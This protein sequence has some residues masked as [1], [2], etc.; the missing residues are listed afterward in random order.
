L[1]GRY[2]GVDPGVMADRELDW[3][4]SVKGEAQVSHRDGPGDGLKSDGP[5]DK[6]WPLP[7]V[8]VPTRRQRT[9]IDYGPW[10]ELYGPWKELAL[11]VFSGR[12]P[13]GLEVAQT[14]S[15]AGLRLRSLPAG[16]T[17]RGSLDLR[18]CQRLK[19]IG[20]RLD[21]RDDLMIGGRCPEAPWWEASSAADAP[22]EGGPATVLRVLSRDHQCPLAGLPSGL[23]VGR[24]LRLRHCRRLERLPDDIR[25][26]RSVYLEGCTSLAWLPSQFAVHGDLTVSAAPSLTSLPPGLRVGGSLRLVGVRVERLPEGLRVGGDLILECCPR[27]ATLPDR[28]DVGGSL[29]VRRCPIDRLPSCLRVGRDVRLHRLP[30]LTSLPESLSVPGRL[31][32]NRC[33][34]LRGIAHGIR[35]GSD[36]IIRRCEGVRDL[37]E[38]L[39][40]PGTLDLRGCTNLEALPKGLDVGSDL[41][42]RFVPALRLADC[43]ALTSLP[44]DLTVGGPIDVAGSGLRGLPERLSRSARILWRGVVVPPEVIFRPETLTPEQ[45][46]GQRNAELRRVMLERVGLDRVLQKAKAEVVDS[47]QDP[48][49]ARRLVRMA[50]AGGFGRDR[51]RCY[52]HC[53]CPSTGREYLLRV[54]PETRTCRQAAAWLAGFEDPEAYRP[55]LET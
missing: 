50:L 6:G 7:S 30:D 2:E 44:E 45:I 17:V 12:A 34:S 10:K 4:G 49:G 25:I 52:L 28:L 37:P 33:P 53:R 47:D 18:Q 16:M 54:P 24:D 14:L 39:H 19:R 3:L 38:G 1:P 40:I 31:E 41:G 22:V 5:E 32:L 43:P 46:L 26:G 51:D 35:V 48:G 11:L 13:E 36:L 27:L 23:R 9:P 21:V 15:L 29:V 42:T 8:K 20:D 55:V